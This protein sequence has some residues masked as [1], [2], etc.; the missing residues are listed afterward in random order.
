MD[1]TSIRELTP[2]EIKKMQDKMLEILLYF[3]KFC[4]E[5]NLMFY[6]AGGSAIGALRHKGF[7]PWDDDID[8]FM[9]RADYE[10][11]KMY[12]EKDGDKE[13]YTYCRSDRE[14]NYHHG[15]AS[16][17]DNHTTFINKYGMDENI[18]HG[19]AI[20]F[21]PID[22]YP[23]NPFSRARQL[24]NAFVYALFNFQRLPNNKGKFLRY[25]AKVIYAIVPSKKIRDDIWIHAEKQMSK[26]KWEDCEYVT[27]LIGSVKGM[28]WKHPKEWFD[29]VVYKEFEGH[30]MPLM[31]GYDEYMHRIWGDY[32]QLP[33]V[34]KRVVRRDTVYI[35]TTEPYTK[36][37]GI[38][39]CVAKLDKGDNQTDRKQ[40]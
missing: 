2:D 40:M 25:M 34:E 4:D 20:E 16:L 24:F 13:N 5:H 39:Y 3:K 27:E 31:A 12:W 22:G 19:M 6:L 37:K 26:Y 7:I 35:S 9:L 38:Y 8:C 10:K 15:A 30:R 1:A 29:H 32:M 18:C 36:F 23:S 33:P 21:G 11:F 28:M 14:H 17:R